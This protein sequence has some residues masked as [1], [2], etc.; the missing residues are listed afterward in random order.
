MA[1]QETVAPQNASETNLQS[2]VRHTSYPTFIEDEP[3]WVLYGDEDIRVDVTVSVVIP[4]MNEALNLPY[5]LPQIPRGVSEV[6]IVDGN[7]KDDTVRVALEIRPDCKIVR[8]SGKG[9]GD[10]LRAGFDAATGDIIV[11]LDA[12]GS[13]SPREI[14]LYVEALAN[15]ADVV[16]GSRLMPGGG[17]A[18]FTPLR[19]WGNDGLRIAFGML[20]GIQYTDLCYGYMA[21]W[22]HAVDQMALDCDGFEIETLINVRAAKQNLSVVE[23]PSIEARRLHGDSNLRTFRDGFRVLRTLLTEKRSSS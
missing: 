14:P 20:Y 19:K 3:R 8:Q 2:D 1:I 10:A 16:T 11:M 17:S 7:S 6:I 23:V 22:K 15:G 13:M 5:L 21:F 9:K 4:A 12:D 18:D